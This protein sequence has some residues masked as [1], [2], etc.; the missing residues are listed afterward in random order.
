MKET[1]KNKV[2]N[3]MSEGQ[4][5]RLFFL[6]KQV[7]ITHDVFNE[8]LPGWTEGRASRMSEL[9]FID[10]M[11]II[12][13]LTELMQKPKNL[14]SHYTAEMDKKRKGVI[15]AVFR[16]MELQNKCPSMKY[17][18]GIIRKAGGVGNI[19]DLTE[20]D[21]QRLYAEFCRKQEAQLSMNKE[22]ELRFSNN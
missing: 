19:N 16:W 15:K 14:K 12:K 17:V 7:N 13:Y 3:P 11:H 21:L 18:L 9:Q 4:R 8:M 10:A 1:K 20:V 22:A 6:M 2:L 5:K